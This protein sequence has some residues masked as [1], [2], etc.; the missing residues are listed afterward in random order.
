MKAV[1]E[2][3]DEEMKHKRNGEWVGQDKNIMP[4]DLKAVGEE[5]NED[6]GVW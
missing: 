3:K 5:E 2:E 1:G 4:L 6:I